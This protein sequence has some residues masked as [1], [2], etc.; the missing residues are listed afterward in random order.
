MGAEFDAIVVGARCAGAP[1]AMLLARRGHRVLLV[2]RAIFPSDTVSTHFLHPP[3]VAALERWGLLERLEA[4]GCPAYAMYAF[5]FGPFTIA[6]TPRVDGE[7]ATAYCP[8]RTVLD[9]LLVEAAVEAGVEL[10]EGVTVDHVLTEDARVTGIAGRS[11]DGARM[12]EPGRVVIGA[13]GRR[14]VFARAVGASRYHERPS[15]T[16]GYYAYWS[17]LQADHFTGYIRPARGFASAPTHDDL[18]M[19]TVSWPHSELEANRHDVEGAFMRTI[20]LV[21]EFAER[22]RSATRETRFAGAVNLP[23]FFAQPFGPGWALVG[24]AGYHK[25]PLTAQG[26]S[27]AFRDAEAMAEALDDVFSGRA[28]FDERLG[29]YQ[30]ERDEAAMP[31]FELTC[32]FATL[33]P[34]PPDMAQLLAATAGRQEAMDDFA[35]MFAGTMPVAAFFSPENTARILAGAQAAA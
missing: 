35:S 15:L 19:L 30:R 6:G 32:D 23:G 24:D 26:I 9:E 10:R 27:D 31:M 28:T 11:K 16:A 3:G 12:K 4:T 8:R 20:D 1:T 14:S 13:D 22:L 29:G 25:D 5:D 18:T 2:D 17:G 7:P 33:E 21:P 34:P